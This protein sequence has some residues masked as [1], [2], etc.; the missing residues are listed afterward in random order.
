MRSM[1]KGSIS[2]GL[3]TIPI[4][5]Y[6]ATESKDVRFNLLHDR[7]RTPVT[8]RKW[9]PACDEEVAGE[10]IVKGY[11]YEKG[12]Y[13][14]MTDEDFTALPVAAGHTLDIVDFVKLEQIDPIYFEKTY[15]LE[16]GEGGAKAYALLR[17]AMEM[18]GRIAI[19]RIVIRS[20]ESL[21]AIRVFQNGVLAMETMHFPDEVRS[22]AGLTGI[23]EPELRQ[24]EI[25]MATNLVASL[26]GDFRPEKFQNEYREAVLE[27]ISAKVTGEEVVAVAAPAER[28][29]VVDLMEALRASIRQAEEA[30]GTAAPAPGVPAAPVPG[31][32]AG[33]GVPGVAAAPVPGVPVGAAPAPGAPG[34]APSPVPGPIPPG[35][36]P[37]PTPGVT[38]PGPLQ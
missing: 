11:E 8:Y 9:C 14:V 5:L 34:L 7:C 13:V 38:P 24:Q 23:I 19:A 12:R 18:T 32:G 3:V 28:G 10:E 21:A 6:A 1:W 25:E 35:A 37:L 33:P 31:V 16:P 29:R 4:K 2:F 26:A 30:R 17:R 36:M 27:R 15:Y 20:K 22:P